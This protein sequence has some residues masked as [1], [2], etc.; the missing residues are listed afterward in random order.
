MGNLTAKQIENLPAGSYS[1]GE[2]LRFIVKPT[3]RKSWVLRYQLNGKRKDMGLGSY[4][5]VSLKEARDRASDQ[6]RLLREQK[7]PL[8][9]KQ[10]VAKAKQ[11]AKTEQ[12]A[13]AYTFSMAAAD[14]IDAHRSGWKNAK[15]ADQWKNTLA[16]YA[17]PFIG[18][19][20]CGD[21]DTQDVLAVLTPIWSKKPETASRVRN[22]IELV[23]DAAKAKGL[24][25]GDNPARWRNH[26]DKLLPKRSKVQAVKH[27][28]ALPWPELPGFVEE[29]SKKDSP[30]FQAILMTI[31]TACR[32]SE[33]LEAT[34][35]EFD[36]K[37]GVW[38][39]PAERMKAEKPHRVPL[40]P[41][42]LELLAAQPRI[43]GTPFVFPGQKQGRPLS[44][45][46]ML[47]ALRRIN[48]ND[49]T[50]H[51]FRSTF[52]DW[53]GENTPYPWEVCEMAL[54]HVIKDKTEAAY[55]RG[56]L[57]EKRRALMTD[58]AAYATSKKADNVVKMKDRA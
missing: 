30:A 28:A 12:M 46:S 4:P 49:L 37:A 18:H 35:S 7:D 16:T 51:G 38:T 33:V 31:F 13:E 23:I 36:L 42:V 56:D 3:G 55:R 25:T 57:F 45:T 40:A 39:I 1:D 22:R 54:A 10:E 32:T 9:E 19:K 24:S 50:M 17:A 58:W 34:W 8:Q 20:A 48:R 21:I 44:N 52:R 43:D 29:I 53:A 47:M 5:G 41:E 15:H 6:R 11:A 14:Y 27:H 2:G 26:L